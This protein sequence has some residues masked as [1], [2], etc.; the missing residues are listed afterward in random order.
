[1]KKLFL[2]LTAVLLS[3][4][5]A[6]CAAEEMPSLRGGHQDNAASPLDGEVN[7]VE[8]EIT[9]SDPE[10]PQSDGEWGE[11]EC[12]AE[13]PYNENETATDISP[14]DPAYLNA[15]AP[16]MMLATVNHETEQYEFS[17]ENSTQYEWGYGLEPYFEKYDEEQ[18]LWLPVDPITEITYIEIYCLLQPGNT[19]T[20]TLPIEQYYGKLPTGMY[21]TGLLMR[22]QTTEATEMIWG[23]FGI[24]IIECY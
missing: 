20:Y 1:M 13:R 5:L 6:A 15:T 4:T 24:G 3:L 23:E 2:S 21:R 9:V 22:N 19:T 10:A 7:T 8:A 12:I 17:V 16:T 14:S 18:E 11:W